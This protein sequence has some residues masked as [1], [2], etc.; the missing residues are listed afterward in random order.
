MPREKKTHP[1]EIT[2]FAPN[3]RRVMVAG[4]FSD[5]TDLPMTKGKD[6]RFRITVKLADG[7]HCYRFRVQSKSWFYKPD[8]WVTV[9][10][11]YA[12]DVDAERECAVLRVV[13]G[14]RVVDAYEWR[15]DANFLPPDRELV[16]YEMHVGDFSGGEADPFPRGTYDA[17]VDKLDY[18]TDLGVNALE[19]MPFKEFPGENGWGYNPCFFMAS[20]TS[21]GATDRLKRLVDEC[22]ALGMRVIMDDVYNHAASDSPL[23]RIDHDYW[24][25]HAPKDVDLSWGPEF[26]YDFHDQKLDVRPARA[27]IGDVA[28]FWIGEYHI[29]GIR[30]D[31]AK[32]IDNFDFLYWIVAE[33]RKA[34]EGKPFYNVAE[35]IPLD[36][37]VCGPDGPMDGC[38]HESF[39]YVVTDAIV[40]EV[41]FD[42]LKNALDP[43]RMGFPVA[44][45]VV[46]Y[47]G[48][49]DHERIL[50]RIG[51]RGVFGEEAY[52]RVRLG[53]AMLF[54]AMG[55]P[56]IW[57]GDEFGVGAQKSLEPNKIDW[58]LLGREENRRLRTYVRDLVRLR[59]TSAA[60]QSDTIDFIHEDAE[61]G[62]LAYLRRNER[63]GG[64]VVVLNLS[65]ADLKGYP[66]T[67]FPVDGDWRNGENTRTVP[68]SRGIGKFNLPSFE[69]MILVR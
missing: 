43:R 3:N 39:M 65:G 47:L 29:D 57:M 48:T 55:I 49:H 5:W 37:A 69:A 42:R 33:T 22:H 32:Q 28:R 24:F 45:A 34:T 14:R 53:F 25:H 23:A 51:K 40:G 54:T 7:D 12:T 44:T 8:E 63:G 58:Q 35:Y 50:S 16:I 6:G 26:N 19:L 56:M 61:T 30:Y 27:F 46:N 68:V 52:R 1:I 4:T 64:V 41:D 11:P 2:L 21:Y 59:R 9:I 62:V 13:N 67:G 10:D 36:P 15:H 31:A 60:L 18:L 66:V 17:V 38:W 20:E